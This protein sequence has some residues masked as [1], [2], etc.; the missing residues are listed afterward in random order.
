MATDQEP[1]KSSVIPLTWMSDTP[2]LC[3]QWLLTNKKLEALKK[4]IQKQLDKGHMKK[5]V[6]PWNSS[7][8][9]IKKKSSKWKMLTDLR[10]LNSVIQPMGPL[11]PGLPSLTMI[12]KNWPLFGH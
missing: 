1:L 9:V 12:S 6:S 2:I 11:Q 5:S 3:K 7:V 4:L 8:F 10:T